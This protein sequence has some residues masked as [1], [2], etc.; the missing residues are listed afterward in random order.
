MKRTL[1]TRI[2]LSFI[3]ASL[4]TIMGCKED[5]ILN[6]NLIAAGDTVNTEIIPDTLTIYTKTV[7][8]DSAMTGDSI[9]AGI[10]INHALGTIVTDP[11]SGVTNASIYF[12]VVQPKLT[13]TFPKTPDS[14]VLILP[15]SGFTWGDTTGLIPQSF[16]VYEIADSFPQKRNYY[17]SYNVAHNSEVL[18]SFFISNYNTLNDSV[19]DLGVKQPAFFRVKLSNSFLQKIINASPDNNLNT[20]ANFLN[21]F[22]GF[23]IEPSSNAI[24]NALFYIQMISENVATNYNRVNVLFYYTEDSTVNT[25][26][27]FYDPTYAARYNRIKRNYAGSPT[28]TLM[29]STAISDSVFVIQNEPGAAADIII[30]YLKNLPKRPV[31]KA[32]LILTQYSFLGDNANIYS[33]AG[34]LYPQR[35]NDDGTLTPILDRYPLTDVAPLL[36]MD[37]ERKTVTVAGITFTQ[38]KLNIPREVQ[39]AIVEQKDKLHLRIGG[40]S[41]YPAAYRLI[42]G[43]GSFSDKNVSIKLN[44]V[45]S[46][47]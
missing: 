1:A 39:A 16:N 31:N 24:G 20:Y 6:A 26:S 41:G 46:K 40:V 34:R 3:L 30:P 32:E 25:A 37:G 9:Y 38:Y 28:Q 43:G 44:I 27:F 18:G 15:Y 10:T 45:M 12:Q 13:F 29:N 36:F 23:C 35:V 5:T 7:M 8:D 11:Y 19:T 2:T 33:G 17:S 21:Y 42:S 47:I 4:A 22:K 14:A